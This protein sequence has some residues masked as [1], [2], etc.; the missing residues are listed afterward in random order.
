[1]GLSTIS[2]IRSIYPNSKIYYGVR[3]WTA[4]LYDQVKTDA[5]AVIPVKFD[6]FSDYIRMWKL[7]NLLGVD[8]IHEMHLS[9]RTKKFCGIYSKL[10]GTKYTFHNHHLNAKGM[11]VHDQGVVKELIQRD[12]DG[13]FTFLGKENS[14]PSFLD[15]EPHF[16]DLNLEKDFSITFGVV[17][18]RQTKMWSLESYARLAE[19]IKQDFPHYKIKVPLS[20]SAQDKQIM[21]RLK[22]LDKGGHLE[23]VIE[24]L[25]KLPFIVGAS[26]LYIGN[27]TGLKHLAIAC[28][29][30]SYTF[31]GPEPPS[32]WHPY[33]K[34]KHPFFY[35]DE[36]ECRTRDA[37]YCGLSECD[38]MICLNDIQ[39]MDVYNKVRQDLRNV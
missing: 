10:T 27:D 8:H 25:A 1:M 36:L 19:V 16:N 26:D 22:E 5:D 7:F 30:K 34:T 11:K 4:G 13:A 12:I 14:P 35:I 9:G 15:F 18:T 38:S 29:V 32:E 37:H 3:D 21:E 23:F 20:P 31:F 6:T 33:N 2:Y 24:P 28:G 17:A 39:V